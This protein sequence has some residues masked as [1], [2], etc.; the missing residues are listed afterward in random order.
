MGSWREIIEGIA[1]NGE[2]GAARLVRDPRRKGGWTLLVEEVQQSYVD[3]ENPAHLFFE[4]TRR[5]GSVVDAAFPEGEPIRV[6][7]LGGG[8]FT[9]PRYVAATRPG[10]EQL[11]VE[12][13]R[14]LAAFVQRIL[15]LPPEAGIDLLFGDA[16]ETVAELDAGSYDLIIG[17]VYDAAQMP[18]SVSD[19][20]FAAAVARLLAPG[21]VYAL[22]VADLAPLAFSRAQ[23][24]TLRTAFADLCLIVRPEL[25]RG[26]RF[27]N[28]VFAC[29]VEPD[30]LP[31]ARLAA[32]AG[33]DRQ[34]AQVVT[35]TN[36]DLLMEGSQPVHRQP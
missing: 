5:L 3:M 27:G 34:P 26:R 1:E 28:V 23:G 30:R 20:D 8:A 16:R 9:M 6:L 12:R 35:G 17:D 7:H 32:L 2:Y 19:V 4:Y 14:R 25:L 18:E 36:L 21:G 10:S 24:A 31:I 22:N 15:P 29:A 13:D 33:R 11:V